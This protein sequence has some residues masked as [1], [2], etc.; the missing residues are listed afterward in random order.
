MLDPDQ[1]SSPSGEG[2]IRTCGWA[3][4][5]DAT[6]PDQQAAPVNSLHDIFFRS[7]EKNAQS[8]CL[9]WRENTESPYLWWKYE[10]TA[11]HVRTARDALLS[12]GLKKG[13]TVGFY[14]QNCPQ[15]V[16]MQYAVM[17][18]GLVVVP[19]YD[20]LGPNILEYVSNHSLLKA[21]V[22]SSANFEKLRKVRDAEKC[23]SISHVI[24]L[25][26]KDI[27]D[28]AETDKC[29]KSAQNTM[30]I[31]ELMDKGKDAAS[32]GAVSAPEIT[33]DDLLVIMYTSGTTGNPKGV[34][35]THR[36]LVASVA[37]ANVFFTKWGYPFRSDDV[38]LSYLPLSHI[39]EQQ[40]EALVLCAGACIGFYSGNIKLILSDLEAL[41]PTVFA[42]VPRVYARFQQRIEENVE[43]ASFI[44]KTLFHWAYS[45]QVKAEE[46]PGEMQRSGFWDALVFKKVR[47][48]ILPRCRFAITGSA[49]MSGQTNDFLKVC[50]MCPITQ[51]YGLTETVGGMNCSIPGNSK[52]GTVGGPLPG[53]QVKLRDLPDMGYSSSDKPFPRGEICVKGDIVFRGYHKNEEATAKAFDEDGF[54]L[55]GDV[56][57][58]LDDGSLQIIDR[59][60]NLFK[61]SQG[62]YVSPE[63]LEQEY[64]KAK[65]VGQVWVYGNSLHSSLLGVV[66]PDVVA[67]KEW[68]EK[69]SLKTLE[70]IVAAPNF[71]KEL[72]AQL[73]EMRGKSHFKKYEAIKD[74]VIEANNLNELG[75]GFTVDNDL[76]TPSF[77]LKRPQLKAKYGAELEALYEQMA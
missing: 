44:Q 13:D 38:Y 16:M 4:D 74:V 12:L 46:A 34:E 9:G 20:T 57:Q 29:V 26:P 64:A 7:A 21:I 47:G 30:S 42:G 54:F 19:I 63:N 50:L 77:K 24:V 17:A 71:K 2:N 76:M 14:A 18:A 41:K 33:L 10:T 25:S 43:K 22:V 65:L 66:V 1:V 55:T 8:P 27:V 51:G 31:M 39:F 72:L 32:A 36:A 11:N 45:R 70:S 49:P 15:W 37:S 53:V 69:H 75:Q 28:D 56:G 60:K 48:K 35:L 23:P 67:A 58:W 73:E 6:R 3:K 62:E 61:L 68:G 59:A 52:S 5:F 40:A